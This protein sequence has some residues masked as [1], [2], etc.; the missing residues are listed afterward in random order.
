M[1]WG[2]GPWAASGWGFWWIFP[3]LGLAVCLTFLIMAFRFMST[4]HG[5]MC[6]GGHRNDEATQTRHEISALR[7]EIKNFGT[8]R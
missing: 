5:F 3:L 4:G 7:E 1:C 8:S 6:M 2:F